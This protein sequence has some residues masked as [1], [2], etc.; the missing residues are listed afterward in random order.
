MPWLRV[1]ALPVLPVSWSFEHWMELSPSWVDEESWLRSA[2]SP[3]C[4]PSW[5]TWAMAGI[6]ATA[7]IARS[8]AN[9]I[10]FFFVNFF[11]P[12]F[13]CLALHGSTNNHREGSSRNPHTTTRGGTIQNVANDTSIPT[14]GTRQHVYLRQT[15]RRT[16]RSICPQAELTLARR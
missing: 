12:L 7:T 2:L 16:N 1:W 6:A 13:F 5:V 14:P 9:N 3:S 11:Y 10:S 4:S 8:A 15:L